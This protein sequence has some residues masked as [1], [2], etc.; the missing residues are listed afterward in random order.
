[1]YFGVVDVVPRLNHGR[2]PLVGRG[3]AGEEEEKRWLRG[4]V[5]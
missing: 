1:M 4:R 5:L 3:H 2:G